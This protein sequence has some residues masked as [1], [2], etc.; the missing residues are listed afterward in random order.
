[1]IIKEIGVNVD[2]TNKTF[3][4]IQ[5][6]SPP[7]TS[8][9]LYRSPPTG[10]PH[11]S[12]HRCRFQPNASSCR[13][14]R[15]LHS[16]VVRDASA[17]PEIHA[18]EL[19]IRDHFDC[20]KRRFIILQKLP[21]LHIHCSMRTHSHKKKPQYIAAPCQYKQP[22]RARA[23]TKSALKNRASFGSDFILSTLTQHIQGDLK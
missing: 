4:C 18:A 13:S 23:F 7:I 22:P 16:V 10:P 12:P 1:M 15:P 9:T 6:F 3:N 8:Q 21:R 2:Q 14:P 11:R 17:L 20:T 5:H 19:S